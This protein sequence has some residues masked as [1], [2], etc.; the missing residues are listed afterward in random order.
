MAELLPLC[1]LVTPNAPEL[2]RL[3][4][5]PVTSEEEQLQAAEALG[6]SAGGAAVLAKGGHLP[7]DEVVDLL[8]AEGTC[9]RFAHPRLETRSTH[10]T[11]CTL[12]AAIAA[13]LGWGDGLPQAVGGGIA[14]LQGAMEAAYP[15][16]GE[17]AD[18]GH[19]RGH[20]PVDPFY[21][22]DLRRS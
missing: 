10:G 12:S 16:G 3:T 11:G 9:W 20:G 17:D 6:K 7:G 4:G 18:R 19:G 13:R 22:L 15:L 8:L 1:T 2:E 21:N 14:Y 5:L